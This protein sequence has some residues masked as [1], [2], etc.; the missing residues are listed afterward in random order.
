MPRQYCAP[1]ET[2]HQRPD[3]KFYDTVKPLA[4]HGL[5][6]SRTVL[7]DDS[8]RKVLPDESMNALIVPPFLACSDPCFLQESEE[9]IE[10]WG[11][12]CLFDIHAVNT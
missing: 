9:A 3:G 8:A 7:L 2:R 4:D 12:V 1:D 10:H 6:L 11:M 5:D